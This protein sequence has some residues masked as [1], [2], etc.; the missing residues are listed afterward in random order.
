M[1]TSIR[2]S[3]MA[4]FSLFAPQC[5]IQ[6]AGTICHLFTVQKLHFQAGRGHVNHT[7][8]Q[9]GNPD[10]AASKSQLNEVL[11]KDWRHHQATT[12]HLSCSTK[13]EATEGWTRRIWPIYMDKHVWRKL[14]FCTVGEI[15]SRAVWLTL[16]GEVRPWLNNLSHLNKSQSL[17]LLLSESGC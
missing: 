5:L 4:N 1:C 7:A 8:A 3:V 12:P 16:D 15:S 14:C 13:V 9:S 17:F 6:S 2:T 10:K 11:N